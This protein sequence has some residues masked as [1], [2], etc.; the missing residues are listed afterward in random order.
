MKMNN[1]KQDIS[2]LHN[3]YP[4]KN[5]FVFPKGLTIRDLIRKFEE[6]LKEIK[7]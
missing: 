1:L 5:F 7:K 2:D 3:K 6:I 4:G